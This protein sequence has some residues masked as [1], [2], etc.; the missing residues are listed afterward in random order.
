LSHNVQL[1]LKNILDFVFSLILFILLLPVYLVI[2]LLIKLEDSGPVIFSQERLGKDGKVFRILKFR[3]MVVYSEKMKGGI[4]ITEEDSRITKIGKVLRKTSLDEI[5]QLINIIKGDMSFIGPRPPLTYY[6][7][8][9]EE[10]EDWVKVR[11]R[12][13]PGITGL[14]QVN[15]RNSIEWYDRF[16]YDTEY[17][18]KWSLAFD[19]KI[20]ID[21]VKTVFKGKGIYSK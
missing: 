21:T 14:A 17:V 1:V 18:K 6:P 11:F 2:S 3:S 20:L 8:K 7:K 10:Y 13:K 12:V 16:E 9:Y 19:F 4:F 15:G 5:P